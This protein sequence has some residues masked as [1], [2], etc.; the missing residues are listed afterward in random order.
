MGFKLYMIMLGM[1]LAGSANTIL[2][3]WQNCLPGVEEYIKGKPVVP[4]L[5]PAR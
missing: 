2:T 1:L 3:K 5:A 4:D